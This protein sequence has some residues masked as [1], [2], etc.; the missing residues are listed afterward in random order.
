[1]S[2]NRRLYKHTKWKNNKYTY[3]Y[4]KKK[5]QLETIYATNKY[6]KPKET[7]KQRKFDKSDKNHWRRNNK[8]TTRTWKI[9][10]IIKSENK[11][12]NNMNMNKKGKEIENKNK[13]NK[14]KQN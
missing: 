3:T 2:I 1:M 14:S 9:K 13:I 8:Y 11:K 7:K 4:C 6:K 12:N 10:K 5:T